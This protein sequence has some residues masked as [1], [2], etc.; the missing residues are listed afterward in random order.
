MLYELGNGKTVNLTFEQW[1]DLDDN[2]IQ[3][4]IANDKGMIL[5]DPFT[6]VDYKEFSPK[7][8]NIPEVEDH[9]EVLD[10]NSLNKIKKE[11]DEAD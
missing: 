4:L 2:K 9:I 11:I 10:E 6:N 3:Q 1:L 5:E 7:K 8:Y